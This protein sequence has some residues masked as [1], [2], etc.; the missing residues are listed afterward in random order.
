MWNSRGFKLGVAAALAAILLSPTVGNATT[1]SFD[2]NNV[3]NFDATGLLTTDG[4]NNVVA[5]TGL[6]TGFGAGSII[7]AP[8]AGSDA[9]F[10]YDNKLFPA[11]DPILDIFGI[12]FKTANYEFNVWGNS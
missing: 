11:A 3:G 5:M 8:G 6:V 1:Y 10:I 4:S 9:A 12:L 7:F 2:F